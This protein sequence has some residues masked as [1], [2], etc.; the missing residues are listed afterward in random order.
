MSD[1]LQ[2]SIFPNPVLR[3]QAIPVTLEQIKTPL[4]RETAAAMIRSMY[5]HHGVGLAAEQVGCPHAIV[6]MDAEYPYTGKKA[7]RVF[8][9]P[10]IVEADPETIQLD[11]PGEGCL[12]LPY[13]YHQPVKRWENV[14]VEWMDARGRAQDKWFTGFDA[15]VIQHEIDHLDGRLFVDHLSPLKQK[16]FIAKV[17]KAHRQYWK[18]VKRGNN[19]IQ[20]AHRTPAFNL[21]RAKKYEEHLR[22][23]KNANH[24]SAP[25]ANLE[26]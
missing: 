24:G 15:I 19:A 7:P 6:V 11:Y 9:N 4:M 5:H 26:G 16:M 18:G 21:A 17:K 8:Y 2:I 10:K 12:S 23:K 13:G 1:V 14:R 25:C 20:H 22:E 3:Q